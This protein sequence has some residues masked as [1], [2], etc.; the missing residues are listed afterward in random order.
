MKKLLITL[1]SI[2]I[3]ATAHAAPYQCFN[4]YSGQNCGSNYVMLGLNCGAATDAGD[5]NASSVASWDAYC[6]ALTHGSGVNCLATAWNAAFNAGICNCDTGWAG[7]TCNVC[8]TGYLLVGGSCVAFDAH[9]II[10]DNQ[11][12]GGS[13]APKTLVST[14]DTTTGADNQKISMWNN[15]VLRGLIDYASTSLFELYGTSA[16]GSTNIINGKDSSGA[17]QFWVDTDGSING[18]NITTTKA[19]GS[20]I[21][22]NLWTANADFSSWTGSVPD[23]FTIISFGGGS[24]SSVTKESVIYRSAPFSAKIYGGT[25][26]A[27]DDI[28][29]RSITGLTVGATYGIG[30]YF[31]RETGVTTD[32]QFTLID[33]LTFETATQQWISKPYRVD[34]TGESGTFTQ[35][36]TYGTLTGHGMIA[37]VG[38]GYLIVTIQSGTVTNGQTITSGLGITATAST[39]AV[40]STANW[41]TLMPNNP[42]SKN[43]TLSTDAWVEEGVTFTAPASGIVTAIWS[44]EDTKTIYVDDVIFASFTTV[45][46]TVF[47]FINGSD[48]SALTASDKLIDFRLTGG[49][50][51][52]ILNLSPTGVF[53]SDYFLT[54]EFGTLNLNLT[55]GS[56]TVG[57]DTF[58]DGVEANL[59]T[60]NLTGA[61]TDYV[62]HFFDPTNRTTALTYKEVGAF[63]TPTLTDGYT[64]DNNYLVTSADNV[65]VIKA[66]LETVGLAIADVDS[67]YKG[68][69]RGSNTD[70]SSAHIGA[71]EAQLFDGNG[72]G[73]L[74]A[75][76]IDAR[77]NNFDYGLLSLGNDLLIAA[78]N[79]EGMTGVDGKNV[80]IKAS[81]AIGVGD[82]NGGRLIFETGAGVGAGA[83]GFTLFKNSGTDFFGIKES[84]LLT[85]LEA[86]SALSGTGRSILLK[87]GG[88]GVGGFNGGNVILDVGDKSGAGNDGYIQYQI[89]GTP[90]A[91]FSKYSDGIALGV[92]D[93]MSSGTMYSLGHS[94]G[95]T[96]AEKFRIDYAG[97]VLLEDG[98]SAEPILAF[99]S[100]RYSGSYYDYNQETI[101]TT[102]QDGL[103][104]SGTTKFKIKPDGIYSGQWNA[105][106]GSIIAQG[107]YSDS[108]ASVAMQIGAQVPLTTDGANILELFSTPVFGIGKQKYL[109]ADKLEDLFVTGTFNGAHPTE[110]VI[111]IDGEGTGTGGVD[112]F[113]WSNNG[114]V[115][116]NASTVDITGAA[117]LL[118][119]GVSVRFKNLTGHTTG[120]KQEFDVAPISKEFY[121]DIHGGLFAGPDASQV[122]FTKAFSIISQENT[123]ATSTGVIGLVSEVQ[124]DGTDAG[125]AFYGFG[126]T[127]ATIGAAGV[128]GAG[129]VSAT[130]DTGPAYGGF[131]SASDSHA[132][133]NIAVNAIALN[134][135]SGNA[136]SIQA[137]GIAKFSGQFAH[138]PSS[139]TSLSAG[140]TITV[141]R[142]IMRVAGNGGA[143]TL[144]STPTI[145]APIEDGTIVIIQGDDDTNTVTLQDESSL[146]DTDL[147]LAGGNNMVLGKGD[148]ITLTY[149][150]GDAKWYEIARSNN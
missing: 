99:N 22:P 122:D 38:T 44:V 115:S 102:I 145:T 4:T 101:A 121:V 149:D 87:A 114:G 112:T 31:L 137:S 15:G 78:V 68:V 53:D 63:A 108:A 132:G 128:A 65:S 50:A 2:F 136:Y 58:L 129:K 96:Y 116:W 90:F 64:L 142:G 75:F 119:N 42:T 80:T 71:F 105:L 103:T 23:N 91:I 30:T 69:V 8:A 12:S 130:T 21:G 56:L 34:F 51:G 143:V 48:F 13:A 61:S 85:T 5:P 125:Y 126:M 6:D 81:D 82:I 46:G 139:T 20:V 3:A 73:S 140:S 131:F 93:V 148:T 94:A 74:S 76:L 120:D 66:T 150:S 59:Y 83:D 79:A 107:G 113:R 39:D 127:N 37:D 54:L 124:S 14:V 134:A 41:F 45:N 98:T 100:N 29:S 32:G 92:Y 17:N 11:T 18:S 123:G 146:A 43:F 57:G 104:S 118:V 135:G 24:G 138:T 72:T 62:Q 106:S 33:S 147:Q 89:D 144:T 47:D 28:L 7:S 10:Y 88:A 70:A 141:T 110:F 35:G 77:S 95:T 117:Q 16:D 36:D 86:Y 9:A 84:T 60:N 133:D 109:G 49:T 52:S 1:F 26:G 55:T 111:E 97:S 67:V 40:A 27:P 25:G 19:L